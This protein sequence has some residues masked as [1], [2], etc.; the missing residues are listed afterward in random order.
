MGVTKA[1]PFRWDLGLIRFP[2]ELPL[3]SAR[4]R[5]VGPA[6]PRRGHDPGDHRRSSSSRTARYAHSGTRRSV[7]LIANLAMFPFWGS[8]IYT[9]ADGRVLAIGLVVDDAI[10]V[11]EAVEH[12]IEQG[13]RR[14]RRPRRR[15]RRSR[16]LVV[17]IALSFSRF[18]ADHF[19]RDHGRLCAIAV[20]IAISVL[21]S[22][23]Q[24]KPPE[25]VLVMTSKPKKV[26]RGPGELFMAGSTGSEGDEW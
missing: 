11:V 14:R 24:A 4:G 12:D 8:S 25:P 5:S 1:S 16:G 6:R 3:R 17:A 9:I 15:W 20:T 19:I 21:I 26:V 22:G 23:I 7:S 10:V 2:L 18:S 13:G